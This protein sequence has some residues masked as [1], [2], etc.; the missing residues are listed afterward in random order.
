MERTNTIIPPLPE[1]L[2]VNNDNELL[3]KLEK[4][5]AQIERGEYLTHEEVFGRLKE[6]YGI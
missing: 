5:D 3:A 1:C 6:T 4:A 2:I